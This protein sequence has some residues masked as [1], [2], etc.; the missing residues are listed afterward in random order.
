MSKFMLEFR[1]AAGRT[2]G[3]LVF[4]LACL[5]AFPLTTQADVKLPAM[6]TDHAVLQR[7]MP[8][9]VWGTADP[10]EEVT[11]SFV[12][13]AIG[14]RQ[15]QKATA[16]AEGNWQVTLAPL[17]VGN[18]LILIVEGKNRIEVKDILVGEVWLCSG[19]S[20][21]EWSVSNSWNGDLEIA[22]ANHP[23][24]RLITVTGL[25]S[26]TPVE[27]FDGHWDVCSPETVKE[28]SA[29]GY[30]FAR[31]LQQ[32]IGVPIGLIDNSW[33]GSACDAWICRDR[34]E[35]NPLYE[36]QLAHWDKMAVEFDAAK[37][38]AE[39]ENKLAEW[40]KDSAAT[41]AAL[42]GQGRP[43]NLYHARLEPAMPFAIR[44]VIWY[45]GESN[46]GRAYQYREMFPLMVRSW[47][48]D[49]GQGDFPF[50]WVQLADFL[51]EKSE[52]GESEWAELREAQT[53]A[54]DRLPNMGEAVIIDIGEAADVHPRNKLE[55]A[56]RLARWA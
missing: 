51:P 37:S 20:N 6:F 35:G 40:E 13:G 25:G 43:A 21:M 27:D 3:T 52:P 36:Q 54:Q 26:Q 9:P 32:Q 45:Q 4:A 16:D 30:L 56:R 19:Q 7:D 1:E 49:W 29:V 39:S 23:Q 10:G 50:Y 22:A 47:R 11:V 28:F 8:V 55:V 44:G 14:H 38:K 34:M 17:A 12:G 33:G 18:P 53:M 24:I 42:V 41:R 15:P 31:E 2:S 48:E 46:A 5:M